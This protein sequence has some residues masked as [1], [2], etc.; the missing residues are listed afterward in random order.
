MK[1]IHLSDIHLG[2]RVNEY[3]MIEDQ[4]YILKRII[5]IVDDEMP[6][7]VII[8]GDVYDKSVP[9][10]EAVQLFDDFLVRLAKRK[11]EVFV[12]SGNH[13]SPE[14]IAFA[15]RIMDASGIHMSPVYTG[16]IVPISM[17]DE[18][19]EVTVYMLPFVKPVNVRRFCEDEITTYTEAVKHAVLKMNINPDNRN[20]LVTHQFVTGARRSESEEISVGGTDNVDAGVFDDFD[21]VALG[22]IHSP[23]NCGSDKIR[24]CGTPL[25]Y[26]FSEARD[27]KSVT[28]VEIAEKGNVTYRTVEL[29]PKHDLVELKGTYAELTLKSFY[30]NT[31]WQDDYTHITLTDEEDV[32]DAIGKLRTVYR[33]LMKLDYDNKRTR[34]NAEISGAADT[35]SKSPL[36]LFSDFYALQNNQ[37]MNEEQTVFMQELIQNIW[38]GK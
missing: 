3:S 33:R 16:E 22:H 8:A 6:D 35:E 18:Y 28:V 9:S 38:E 30:E 1:L 24:Y 36:E 37:L 31:T 19:G 21:Y 5:N 10:A 7:G 4:E 2:K 34:S 11:I 14:R 12:I 23:Q 27:K 32:P 15:S 13:D 25:K 17:H 29:V 26:S 20:V